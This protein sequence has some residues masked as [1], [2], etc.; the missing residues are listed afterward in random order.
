MS[1]EVN[2]I[3][4]I[5]KNISNQKLDIRQLMFLKLYLTPGTKYFSNALQSAIKAGFSREYAESI[6]QKDL[7]WLQD[8]LSEIVGKETDIDNLRK[9]AR[10]VLNK[11]LDSED[12]AIAQ[13]TAKFVAEKTDKEFSNKDQPTVNVVVP[14]FG[15]R[16]QES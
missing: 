14:I 5:L 10:K 8:G 13:N 3:K 9:K 16:S 4:Y 7:K 15:G 1:R 11:S 6:L 12:E 2:F